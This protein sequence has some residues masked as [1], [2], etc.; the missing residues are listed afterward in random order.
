MRNVTGMDEGQLTRR[1]RTSERGAV[2]SEF[3]ALFLVVAMALTVTAGTAAKQGALVKGIQY[4]LCKVMVQVTQTLGVDGAG[5]GDPCGENPLTGHNDLPLCIIR[6]Q[7][8][9]LGVNGTFRFIRGEL[10]G[11]DTIIDTVDPETGDEKSFVFLKNEAGIGVEAKEGGKGNLVSKLKKNG[12]GFDA[13]AVVQGGTGVVYEFD[14]HEDAQEFLDSRRGNYFT[15]AAGIITGGKAEALYDG[16]RKGLT[17][18]GGLVGIGD[19]EYE[20]PTPSGVTAELAVQADAGVSFEKGTKKSGP[21]NFRAD[22][23]ANGR[24]GGQFR[25]NFDGTSRLTV[26]YEGEVA[27]NGGV[28]IDKETKKKLPLLGDLS[29][30][31]GGNLAGAVEYRVKFDKHGNPTNFILR[32]ESGGGWQYKVGADRAHKS[33]KSQELTVNTYNLDLTRPENLE[34]FQESFPALVTGGPVSPLALLTNDTPLGRRILDDSV[35]YRQ[36]FDVEGATYGGK[37]PSGADEKGIKIK[38]VGIGFNDETTKKT[39][40]SAE[41]IDH[42]APGATW[43]DLADCTKD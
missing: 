22:V 38:G 33:G 6:H 21:I 36:V 24:A 26:R 3:L 29:A 20:G 37:G 40:K 35:Q 43:H 1:R 39:L 30:T 31:A 2:T 17:E 7:D 42:S 11:K 25:Y 5:K 14:S 12:L 19:G 32:T 9:L 15:R 8:R 34:A 41:Y 4:G 28:G 16:V 23:R 18:L 10:T 27:G 13:K